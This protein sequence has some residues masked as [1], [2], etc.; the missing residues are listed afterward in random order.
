MAN[1]DLTLIQSQIVPDVI[2][3]MVSAELPKLIAFSAIAPVD[4][5]LQG[6]PG[7]TITVPR[8]KYIGD[9][10]D[11]SEGETINYAQLDTD[12]DQWTIKKAG[13]GVK[14]TD[15]TMLA[16]YGDPMGEATRQLSLSIANKIDNDIL[17]TAMQARLTT[18]GAD[19]T[20]LDIIDK[21]EDIFNDDDSPYAVEGSS[22]ITGVLFLNPK[23]VSKLRKAAAQD[24]TRATDL[25]DNIL[26]SGSF[27]ELLGWQIY[28]TKK[29]P[30]GSG[31]AVK[32]G[33]MKTFIKRGAM[34]ETGRDIDSKFTK[35][36]VDEHYGVAIYDDTKILAINPTEVEGTYIEKNV[37][38]TPNDG[39]KGKKYADS[40]GT[41][42]SAGDGES[43]TATQKAAAKK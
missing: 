7:T 9:A 18:T 13:K 16:G 34:V 40:K 1:E 25:G 43:T 37:K 35:V 6:Q 12:S 4:T 20:S 15:E 42:A 11:F 17:A 2:G 5:T 3:D 32:P 28:R 8:F 31:L 30:A 29:I 41:G 39:L 38:S 27:G 22:P 14:V 21:I 36:N 24:W 23:D 19:V 26:I 33:A 10:T